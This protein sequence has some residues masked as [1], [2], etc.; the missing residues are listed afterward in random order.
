M[1]LAAKV[2]QAVPVACARRSSRQLTRGDYESDRRLQI[3]TVAAVA[4]AEA[5]VRGCQLRATGLDSGTPGVSDCQV[6]V[7]G[8]SDCLAGDGPVRSSTRPGHCAGGHPG[9]KG[10]FAAAAA[11]ES[12]SGSACAVRTNRCFP[13]RCAGLHSAVGVLWCVYRS[14]Q[15]RELVEQERRRWALFGLGEG[16]GPVRM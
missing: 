4:Q 7:A 10:V 12:W 15:T 14:A 6:A 9:R 5:A 13:D 11:V 1:T 3:W 2:T 8:E 16:K